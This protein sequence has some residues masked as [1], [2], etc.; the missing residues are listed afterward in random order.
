MDGM[1]AVITN[2][3]TSLKTSAPVSSGRDLAATPSTGPSSSASRLGP[4]GLDPTKPEQRAVPPVSEP[5]RT[6]GL[7]SSCTQ[8]QVDSGSGAAVERIDLSPVRSQRWA[9]DRPERS[10]RVKYGAPTANRVVPVLAITSNCRS[11]P[12]MLGEPPYTTTEVPQV[13]AWTK[14]VHTINEVLAAT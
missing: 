13:S 12:V 1:G 4:S 11:A 6:V 5:R 3:P 9:G 7:T 14:V 10:P 2:S 8:R